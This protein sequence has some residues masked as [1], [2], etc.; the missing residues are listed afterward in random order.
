MTGGSLSIPHNRVVPGEGDAE[1]VA[2]AVSGGQWVCGPRVKAFEKALAEVA[3][4]K[5]AVCVSSGFAALR[6]ALMTAGAGPSREVLVPAY[7][8]VALANAVLALGAR[9]VPVDVIQ[10]EWTLD[11]EAAAA[12]VTPSTAAIVAVHLFGL[13]ARM[14]ALSA[15]GLPLVEDCAHA[16]GLGAQEGRLGS[17]GSLSM[18]SFYATKLIGA[19]EGGAI[20][21][22]DVGAADRLRAFRDGADQPPHALRGNDKMTDIAAALGA[23]RL[24]SLRS[25]LARRAELARV[26]NEAL[27]PLARDGFLT[28][29]PREPT[30]IWY[31]YAVRLSRMNAE[32]CTHAMARLGIG[33]ARPVEVWCPEA[34]GGLPVTGENWKYIL[35][36]PMY[37]ALNGEE[38]TRVAEALG[39]ALMKGTP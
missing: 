7:S 37:P 6:L 30:R 36:L 21:I 1:A 29:P 33:T 24:R 15:L 3:G 19:G 17:L 9:P 20:F 28:L 34:L 16:L 27:A 14:K 2:G 4:R 18:T 10:D 12:A 35:S 25:N 26:Y 38:A 8:C 13:P 32:D 22:D 5:E 39:K 23:N 31:R 11:P